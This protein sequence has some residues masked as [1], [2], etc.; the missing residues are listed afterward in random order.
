R[1]RVDDELEFIFRLT[2]RVNPRPYELNVGDEVRYESVTDPLLDRDMIIQPDGA[3][4]LRLLGQVR[5]AGRTV[6]GLRDELEE[7]YKEF[8]K[9]GPSG[10]VTPLRVNTL[11]EDLRATVD[12][13]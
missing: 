3:I 1:V 5:A 7:R 8:Y 10:T 6:A 12:S 4:T 2:R 13:R 11:L 9:H